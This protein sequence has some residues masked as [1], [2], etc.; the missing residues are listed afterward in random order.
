MLL[1]PSYRRPLFFI[2][3]CCLFGIL[4]GYGSS[5]L[6]REYCK[7]NTLEIAGFTCEETSESSDCTLVSPRTLGCVVERLRVS[8]EDDGEIVYD[9]CS[10]RA[11]QP[12]FLE[13]GYL[14]EGERS[15]VNEHAITFGTRQNGLLLM[16]QECS[17]RSI[18]RAFAF[19]SSGTS[20]EIYFDIDGDGKCDSRYLRIDEV[21]HPEILLDGSWLPVDKWYGG[22]KKGAFVTVNGISRKALFM[23]D[24]WVADNL[25]KADDVSGYIN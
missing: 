11:S 1:K 25:P 21:N 2:A 23:V 24:K 3:S 13:Y 12:A 16:W 6:F 10:A 20:R 8:K 4:C 19:P 22:K 9:L 15:A 17:G 5:F 18:N 7:R 14:K